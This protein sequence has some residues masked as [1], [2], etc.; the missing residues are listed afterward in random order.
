M[1]H[2][3]GIEGN[4]KPARIVHLDKMTMGGFEIPRPNAPHEWVEHD[5]S[6]P[7]EGVERLAGAQVAIIN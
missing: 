5:F 7:G 1:A 4:G 3:G 6:E 2:E